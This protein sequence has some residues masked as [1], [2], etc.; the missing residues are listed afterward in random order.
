MVYFQTKN[1]NLGKFWRVLQWKMLVYFMAIWPIL[2][3]FSML[4]CH[5]VNFVVISY[6]YVSPLWYVVPI[7]IWQP[8]PRHAPPLSAHFSREFF[9]V[10]LLPNQRD[11]TPRLA[12]EFRLRNLE[13]SKIFSTSNYSDLQHWK[14]A[15]LFTVTLHTLER[16]DLTTH[17]LPSIDDA[18]VSRRQWAVFKR[19][20]MPTSR[21]QLAPMREVGA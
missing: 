9:K 17:K 14:Y 20:Y 3:Q 1:S 21:L 10:V 13:L 5:M 6:T 2:R 4:C 7:Q 11:R 12:T 19:G 18:T 16:F 8:W 15:R